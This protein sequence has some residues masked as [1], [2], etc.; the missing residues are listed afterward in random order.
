MSVSYIENWNRSYSK[1]RYI[2]VCGEK[3]K[4]N[5]WYTKEKVML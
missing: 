5:V 1:K 2:N 3:N 4:K